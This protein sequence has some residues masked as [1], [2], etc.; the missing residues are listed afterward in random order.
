[1]LQSNQYNKVSGKAKDSLEVR[2]NAT[3]IANKSMNGDIALVTDRRRTL[4]SGSDRSTMTE[5]DND[6]E[7]RDNVSLQKCKLSMMFPL[8]H[9]QFHDL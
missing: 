2:D 4:E 3:H 7:S 8:I 6:G 5:G 9:Y 1:M